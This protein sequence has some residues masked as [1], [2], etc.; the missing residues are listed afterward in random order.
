MVSA[1]YCEGRI[2]GG[3]DRMRGMHCKKHFKAE[4]LWAYSSDNHFEMLAFLEGNCLF[5][6][7]AF[8]VPISE[9]YFCLV[10]IQR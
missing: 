1:A 5:I 3:G 4:A 9:S 7:A 10:L 6:T 8:I 2:Q